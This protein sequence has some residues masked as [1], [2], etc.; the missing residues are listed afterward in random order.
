MSIMAGF[1]LIENEILQSSLSNNWKARHVFEDLLKLGWPDGVVNL[2]VS[3]IAYCTKVPVEVVSEA[4]R[5]LEMD[6]P[7]SKSQAHNGRRLI[8]LDPG[9]QWGWKIVN[10]DIYR[11]RILKR[12]FK[13]G[14]AARK[15]SADSREQVQPEPELDPGPE[16]SNGF[17]ITLGMA[18]DWHKRMCARGENQDGYSQQEVKEAWTYYDGNGWMM[19]KI[20]VADYRSAI[21]DRINTL[22]RWAN[23]KRDQYGGIN[24][25]SIKPVPGS[26]AK[27]GF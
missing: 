8:R 7:M 13:A 27:G 10:W 3:E 17:K 5:F 22:R 9:R 16:P 4:I 21:L 20:P 11:Q 12:A 15:R 18:M 24:K 25:Q 2:P 23:E 19:G 6:D 26:V 14:D 1:T